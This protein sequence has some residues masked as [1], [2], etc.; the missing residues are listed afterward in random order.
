MCLCVYLVGGAEAGKDLMNSMCNKKEHVKIV[1]MLF[2]VWENTT[3]IY[4]LEKYFC[5]MQVKEKKCN[6]Q[7]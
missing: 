5:K 1:K 2:V 6:Y 3:I 4:F 7:I